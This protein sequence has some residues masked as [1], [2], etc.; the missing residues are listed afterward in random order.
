EDGRFG[1]AAKHLTGFA[2]Q[3]PASSLGTLA[4]LRLG[5]TQVQLKQF[6]EAIQTLQPLVEK[7]P[8]LADQALRWIGK[9][10]IAAADPAN[11]A[12]HTLALKTAIETFGKSAEQAGKL[13][14]TDPEANAR[15]GE[16]LLEMADTQQLAR[17][18]RDAVATCMLILDEKLLPE[19]GEEV[20]QRL[21]TA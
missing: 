10:Q 21:A 3:F 2:R 15:R 13:T 12:K 5:L 19:R 18:P 11:P 9:A 16:T 14:R 4:Q 8:A 17:L 7:Q 1:D 6:H 20:L